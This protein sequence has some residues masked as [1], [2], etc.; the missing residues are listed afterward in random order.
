[1]RSLRMGCVVVVDLRLAE[2][3]R[4]IERESQLC[5]KHARTNKD[6]HS[7]EGTRSQYSPYPSQRREEQTPRRDS[8]QLKSTRQSTRN[9]SA[10]TQHS[11]SSANRTQKSTKHAKEHAIDTPQIRH[12]L[13]ANRSRDTESNLKQTSKTAQAT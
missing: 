10:T 8:E 11:P 4:R 3:L 2:G 9:L 12:K 6:F 7:C 13:G 5:R 1:M